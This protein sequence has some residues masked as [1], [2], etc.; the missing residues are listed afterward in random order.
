MLKI[1]MFPSN[2]VITRAIRAIRENKVPVLIG[3]VNKGIFFYAGEKL[4]L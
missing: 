4:S 3:A 1:Q 2:C